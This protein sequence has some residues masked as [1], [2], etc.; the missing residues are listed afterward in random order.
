MKALIVEDE[1]MARNQLSR[2]L[3]AHFPDI[4][5]VNATDSVSGTLEYLRTRPDLDIIFM[6]VELSDGDCFEIFRKIG[7]DAT[8]IMTTAYDSYAIKAFEAGCV[9]YLLKP[10]DVGPLSRA[11][12]RCREGKRRLEVRKLLESID[13]KPR[14]QYL[15]RA[16][17]RC[18]D[19]IIPVKMDDIAYFFSEDK[20]NYVVLATGEKYLTDFTMDYL[21]AELDPEMFFRVSRGCVISRKA[22]KSAVRLTNGRLKVVCE[23]EPSSDITVS[24]ARVEDFHA[25]LA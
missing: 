6:D 13:D 23:P 9:D 19:S 1:I 14:K 4:E 16:V 3:K 22:V 7:I 12:G 21:E 24:R 2:L 25:W 20:A 11:I 5:V 8:V 18:G 15:E 10:I 17:F